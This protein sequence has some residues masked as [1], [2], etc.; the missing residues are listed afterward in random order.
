MDNNCHSWLGKVLKLLLFS[1]TINIYLSKQNV[2]GSTDDL[3]GTCNFT[4][5]SRNEIVLTD[6]C[7]SSPVLAW[8][9]AYAKYSPWIEYRGMWKYLCIKDA[10]KIISMCTVLLIQKN[11]DM[12]YSSMTPSQYMH[13]K[14][15]T[16]KAMKQR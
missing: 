5:L 14:Q 16:R 11:R 7:T 3:T 12:E 15:N 9:G 6:A 8:I 4:G 10:S 2:T 13:S 1:D